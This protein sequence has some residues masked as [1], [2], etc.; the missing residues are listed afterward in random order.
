MYR[1]QHTTRRPKIKTKRKKTKRGGKSNV[2]LNTCY[3]EVYFGITFYDEPKLASEFSMVEEARRLQHTYKTYISQLLT[4]SNDGIDIRL[5]ETSFKTKL[6]SLDDTICETTQFEGNRAK[7]EI[8][9]IIDYMS[10]KYSSD[11][12][13]C[14]MLCTNT[15]NVIGICDFSLAM[16]DDVSKSIIHINYL[17][18]SNYKYSGTVLLNVVKSLLYIGQFSRIELISYQK[19]VGFYKK[20]GF[21]QTTSS[22]NTPKMTFYNEHI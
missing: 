22:M 10:N 21:I 15:G 17:C 1:N 7:K 4:H 3:I 8:S 16:F 6:E 18:G 5:G 20:H 13:I 9:S 2:D 11:N 14:F 19:S 12:H